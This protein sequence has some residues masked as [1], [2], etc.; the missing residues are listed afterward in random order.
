MEREFQA[1]FPN[2]RLPGAFLVLYCVGFLAQY[3]AGKGGSIRVIVSLVASGMVASSYLLVDADSRSLC[4]AS[5]LF[6]FQISLVCQP[7]A[8][9]ENCVDTVSV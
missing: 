2:R 4:A 6:S 9:K 7:Q 1:H 5:S 3:L 8:D